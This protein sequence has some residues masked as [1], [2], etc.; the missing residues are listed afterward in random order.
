MMPP[1]TI[2]MTRECISRCSCS[3]PCSRCSRQAAGASSSELLAGCHVD[4]AS[5]RVHRTLWRVGSVQ[6]SYLVAHAP[7]RS[8]PRGWHIRSGCHRPQRRPPIAQSRRGPGALDDALDELLHQRRRDDEKPALASLRTARCPASSGADVYA[9]VYAPR[10]RAADPRPASR[11]ISLLCRG[12]RCDG[13]TRTRTG[14]TTIFRSARALRGV[15]VDL[16]KCLHN[17]YFCAHTRPADFAFRSVAFP[18]ASHTDR[19]VAAA[20]RRRPLRSP[21]RGEEGPRVA[22]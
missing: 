21:S 20:R 18:S 22:C 7:L 15:S 1:R 10:P 4:R 9:G 12:F 16:R 19:T 17:G 6:R 2:I 13:E 5:N 3:D 11:A 8:S 14:D